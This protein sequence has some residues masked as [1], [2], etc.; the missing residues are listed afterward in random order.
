MFLVS[1]CISSDVGKESDAVH[2]TGRQKIPV[3]NDGAIFS[4]RR[5]KGGLPHA[6][7]MLL[8]KFASFSSAFTPPQ[9]GSQKQSR[10]RKKP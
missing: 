6:L 5:A 4:K 1:Y 9:D 10:A 3:E 8:L 7:L 2:L